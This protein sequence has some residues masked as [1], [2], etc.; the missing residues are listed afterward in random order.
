M[1]TMKIDD[2]STQTRWLLRTNRAKALNLLRDRS[3]RGKN[4]GGLCSEGRGDFYQGVLT[5]II[6]SR[7]ADYT[8][9]KPDLSRQHVLRLKALGVKH[10]DECNALT[11]F[12]DYTPLDDCWSGFRKRKT[13]SVINGAE[14]ERDRGC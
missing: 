11:V 10:C 2:G 12:N 1:G 13:N 8:S 5:T 3:C 7:V 9:C 4:N 6:L 14:N